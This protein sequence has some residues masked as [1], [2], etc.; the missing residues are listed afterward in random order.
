PARLELM[1]RERVDLGADEP[2]RREELELVRGDVDAVPV[3]ADVWIVGETWPGHERIAH[4]PLAAVVRRPLSAVV[5][6]GNSVDRPR[7]ERVRG[8]RHRDVEM[9]RPEQGAG[10]R[11]LESQDDLEPPAGRSVEV[12]DRI[13]DRWPSRV[14]VLAVNC[15]CVVVE[16]V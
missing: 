14:A 13:R 5:L 7:P 6:C 2:G 9:V 10:R 11:L 8:A 1:L 12:T 3:R 4:A 16:G 15:R